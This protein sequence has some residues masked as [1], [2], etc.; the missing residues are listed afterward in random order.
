[1]LQN[2]DLSYDYCIYYDTIMYKIETTCLLR[3][4]VKHYNPT[5][6]C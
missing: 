5:K 1:M 2:R 3:T 6:F 4:E